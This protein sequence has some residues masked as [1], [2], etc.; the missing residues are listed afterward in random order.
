M[1]TR[2]ENGLTLFAEASLTKIFLLPEEEP[3]SKERSQGYSMNLL[4]YAGLVDRDMSSW[5][6]RLPLLGAVSELVSTK[7]P[8]SGTMRNG[9]LYQRESAARRIYV[10]AGGA[11]VKCPTPTV[12][13]NYNRKGLSKTSG[14]GLATWVEKTLKPY[15]EEASKLGRRRNGAVEIQKRIASGKYATPKVWDAN[16]S[17]GPV[18]IANQMKRDSPSLSAAII[19]T[20]QERLPTPA[21]WDANKAG[22]NSV[23]QLNRHSP[24]L[25]VKVQTSEQGGGRLN[26]RWVEWLMAFP[27]GWTDLKD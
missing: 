18:E 9:R 17:M 24:G 2:L 15:K 14:D 5:K 8:K 4:E 21:Q 20:E 27:I 26:P 6:T 25:S 1:V 10:T 3:E 7:L 11:F 13:G 19:V 16:R 22:D 23:S 12:S